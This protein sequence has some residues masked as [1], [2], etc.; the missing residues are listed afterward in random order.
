MKP[1]I[2]G[3]CKVTS[4]C[5]YRCNVKWIVKPGW[6]CMRV[7]S[8]CKGHLKTLCWIFAV[9]LGSSPSLKGLKI[10]SGE[11][12]LRDGLE[13]SLMRGINTYYFTTFF[14]S[15][16]LANQA[17]YFPKRVW[18]GG[19]ILAC[20]VVPQPGKCC[21][22]TSSNMPRSVRWTTPGLRTHLANIS[23]S[24][25]MSNI[26]FINNLAR[27][28]WQTSRLSPHNVTNCKL[29]WSFTHFFLFISNFFSTFS[30]FKCWKYC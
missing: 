8:N 1:P 3:I 30:I 7:G 11:K 28:R 14:P 26:S 18:E 17:R 4:H 29:H 21:L 22:L 25:S 20:E 9:R 27:P 5:F 13:P 24:F 2:H 12:R 23:S 6:K 19:G 16:N 15:I 10:A